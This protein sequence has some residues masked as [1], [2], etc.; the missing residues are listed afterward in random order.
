MGISEHLKQR[1]SRG[2]LLATASTIAIAV[3]INVPDPAFASGTSLWLEYGWDVDNVRVSPDDFG[4]PLGP[5]VPSSGLTAPLTEKLNL[6]HSYSGEGKIIF[7]P[8]SSDWLLSASVRY[9]RA[10]GASRT[11][12]ALS[13]IPTTSFATYE[14]TYPY[15]PQSNKARTK[16]VHVS[17]EKLGG[18]TSNAESHL[19]VDFEA[20]KDI[21]IG[22]FGPDGKS[23]FGAGVRFAHFTMS[24]TATDFRQTQGIHF[25]SSTFRT[26]TW[27]G[28]GARRR[29]L[30]D[31]V[32][33]NGS[34]TQDFI[35][36]GPSVTWDAS[37]EILGDAQ[38]G[39]LS[40]DWG[41]N[42]AVLFGK[43]RKNIRHQSSIAGYCYGSQCPP[44]GVPLTNQ[45]H[46]S[47]T[48]SITV[49]NVG[50][51]AGATLRYSDVK[52]SF[53]YRAD[54]FI[55]AVD[56]GLETRKSSNLLLHGPFASIS[57]GL[58]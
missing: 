13:P 10:V 2:R 24:R 25:E 53:G 23:V 26:Y 48:K 33:A 51:F 6:S 52:L 19:L 16:P 57:I 58:P 20:G 22:L 15:F 35:G 37:A 30:W 47:T 17:R 56:S 14:F 43:Q 39:E 1:G 50:G 41:A 34:M 55:G 42:A 38:S 45:G 8:G 18:D 12:Q 46:K 27:P 9:G 32:S 5:M 28:Y 54:L 40:L 11:R 49:P 29:E 36:A 31:V 44:A 3:A 4:L 21:G 7:Q